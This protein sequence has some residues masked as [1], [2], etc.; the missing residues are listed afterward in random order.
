MQLSG[1]SDILYRKT[2]CCLDLSQVCVHVYYIHN[3][4]K[5]NKAQSSPKGPI[6]LGWNF[7]R[8]LTV[9]FRTLCISYG[10]YLISLSLGQRSLSRRSYET[11]MPRSLLN[12]YSIHRYMSQMPYEKCLSRVFVFKEC[13]IGKAKYIMQSKY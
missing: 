12:I 7:S 11:P 1:R 13:I 3:K 2:L 8:F 5:Q 10:L 4:S 6:E 9:S